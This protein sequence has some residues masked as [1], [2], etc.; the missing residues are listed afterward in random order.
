MEDLNRETGWVGSIIVGG[1]NPEVGAFQS[2]VYV[3]IH[4]CI[5]ILTLNADTILAK[6]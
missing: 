6:L 3:P 5:S 4:S 2:F 1:P